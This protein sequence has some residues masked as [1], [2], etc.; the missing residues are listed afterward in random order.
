MPV[1]TNKAPPPTKEY[2]KP[3]N[4]DLYNPDDEAK[5]FFKLETG[6]EDDKL[7]KEH[8]LEVQA[9]AFKVRHSGLDLQGFGR[10]ISPQEYPYPCIRIFEFMK[11]KIARLPDYQKFLD[12]GKKPG[13]I[14]LDLGCCFG[15]DFRKAIRDGIPAEHVIA[16]DLQGAFW[17]LGKELFKITPESKSYRASFIAGDVTRSEFLAAVPPFTKDSP[18]I[19][20]RPKDLHKVKTL[21]EL[22]GHVS[23]IFTGAF[24]H[25][26]EEETQTEIA[27]KLAGLLSPEPGSM[28]LSVQGG[29]KE[30]G[31]WNPTGSIRFMFCHSPESWRELWEDIFG[32]GNVEVR[33]RIRKEEGGLDFYG[34]FPGNKEQYH[35]LEWSVERK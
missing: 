26:F 32:K 35:V 12:V 33:A 22:Q 7:L 2:I 19:C 34:M 31:I 5:E 4:Q 21:N 17:H 20:E 28:L 3:L 24:F 23:A 8:I 14:V 25:L 15:N 10:Q 13:A 16:S 29:T 9:K 1:P 27:R 11:L 30:A 18:P 6:M